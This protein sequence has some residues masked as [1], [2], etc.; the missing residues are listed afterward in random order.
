MINPL[1]APVFYNKPV[2]FPAGTYLVSSTI[3]KRIKDKI[4]GYLGLTNGRYFSGLILLGA[5]QDQTI[6]RLK[7]N[8]P[9][10]ANPSTPKAVI[11]A[12]S[13]LI[14][15][16]SSVIDASGNLLPGKAPAD[17]IAISTLGGKDY[18]NKGEGND[19]YMN[20]IESITVEVGAGNPGA[21]GIDFI[22]S[23]VAAI[24]NVTVRDPYGTALIGISM[25]RFGPGP[26]YVKY[27][28]VSGFDVGIDI[29]QPEYA[30]TLEHIKI[31]NSRSAGLRNNQNSVAVRDLQVTASPGPA[32]VNLAAAGLVVVYDGTLQNATSS[33][34]ADAIQNN[35]Y[36]NLRNVRIA[37]FSTLCG[38]PAPSTADGIYY[39]TTFLQKSSPS[40][41]IGVQDF[42]S[43]S[44]GAL[45]SGAD[46]TSYGADLRVRPI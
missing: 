38:A 12:A 10:F 31:T 7:D 17:V 29:S 6:I 4:S 15:Q 34:F 22:G 42:P 23:N 8:A 1:T 35:G 33:V 13:S 30:V 11:F 32:I 9:G 26:Y 45:T 19:A 40:W 37:G 21:I 3:E 36:L 41:S 39:G 44:L 18:I 43:T 5:C 24:R 16:M 28:Q 46:I 14:L 25:K 27:V 2:Y 20:F